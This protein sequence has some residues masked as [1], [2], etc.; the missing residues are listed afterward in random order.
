MQTAT[1][2]ARLRELRDRHYLSRAA[3]ARSINVSDRIVYAWEHDEYVP[4][5]EHLRALAEL[6][7]VSCDHIRRGE[8]HEAAPYVHELLAAH[9]ETLNRLDRRVEELL[10]IVRAQHAGLL[11]TEQVETLGRLERLT[12]QLEQQ[13]AETSATA[14][15]RRT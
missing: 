15:S 8:E 10:A 7:G 6:F 4:T 13:L 1:V 11:S 3:V 14:R 9:S 12:R 5:H 2:G